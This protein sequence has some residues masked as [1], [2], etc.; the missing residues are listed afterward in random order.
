[1]NEFERADALRV[2]KVIR[3]ARKLRG[4][5]QAKLS[6]ELQVT[7]ATFSNI[8]K[9]RVAISGSL[10][11]RLSEILGLLPDHA[12]FEGIV[13]NIDGLNDPTETGYKIPK[14][15]SNNAYSTVRS[16]QPFFQF[17]EACLGEKALEA[18]LKEKL[19]VEP[20][21]RFIYGLRLSVRFN[22]DLADFLIRSGHL[23]LGTL[24]HVT[25]ALTNPK[26]HGQLAHYYRGA[27]SRLDLMRTF[28]KH[29]SHYE[30]NFTYEVVGESKSSLD[31]RSIPSEFM[32]YFCYKEEELPD[33]INRYRLS[34]LQSFSSYLPRSAPVS[35]RIIPGAT[36]RQTECIF[37]ITT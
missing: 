10:W 28:A 12:F 33:F 30:R 24:D 29:V 22:C 1:M 36:K 21:I 37:R 14:R 35:I 13:D 3:S 31:I 5:S 19:K 27:P 25:C 15:Y 26:T 34:F 23:T 17:F 16:A 32:R 7:Q 6:R 18:F 11:Y 4:I 2:S 20:D 8:E 9:G